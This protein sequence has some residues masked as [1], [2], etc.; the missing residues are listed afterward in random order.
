MAKG[1]DEWRVRRCGPDDVIVLRQSV[2][3]PHLSTEEAR[4]SA[5]AAPEAAHF[6]AENET[7]R[8]VS[9]G[10]LLREAPP[11]PAEVQR[12]WRVR[13]MATASEWRGQ[14]AGS[15]ILAAI[16]ADVAASG[17]GLLWC[18]AR[19]RAV[20]FYERAGMTATGEPWEEP[21]IGPHI[22]MFTDIGDNATSDRR[23]AKSR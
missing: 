11:W 3:R 19:L 12:A 14:G 4:Y 8:V 1:A 5:D 9:V 22:A 7:G 15:A 20:K 18:N 23:S 6:C 16:F 10:S 13:G 21:F 2:L 17:G